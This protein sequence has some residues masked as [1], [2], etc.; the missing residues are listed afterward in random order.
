MELIEQEIEAR[1]R[2]DTSA[3]TSSSSRDSRRSIPSTTATFVV[4][5]QRVNC[6]YCRESHFPSACKSVTDVETRKQVLRREGRCY[7]CLK[8]NHLSRD[9][10]SNIRCSQCNGRHHVSLC[11]R[12][13]GQ[14]NVSTSDRGT[15]SERNPSER[16]LPSTQM[17]VGTKTPV[18]LQTATAPA[19][20]KSTTI[21]ARIILDS[22]SQR[23]YTTNQLKDELAL[24]TVRT[25]MISIKTFG[26]CVE[27]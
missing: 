4:G 1:E 13:Q 19:Y 17:Y 7:V 25:D 5:S 14:K 3:I 9:C 15:D 24:E 2:A 18:L 6:C 8:R 22:G 27:K 23:S 11:Q 21:Q 10:R 26:S 12:A 16:Q 20:G